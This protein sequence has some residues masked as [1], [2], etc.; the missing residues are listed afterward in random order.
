MKM[1]EKE[2]GSDSELSHDK[3]QDGIAR[4]EGLG[5]SESPQPAALRHA[6]HLKSNDDE[7]GTTEAIGNGNRETQGKY[8]KEIKELF[9]K[10]KTRPADQL[11]CRIMNV[12]AGYSASV[13][14]F[15]F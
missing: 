2:E 1:E 13:S 7:S 6:D 9:S 12:T 8:Y 3:V 10:K 15:S 14:Q 5:V 11:K 4:L